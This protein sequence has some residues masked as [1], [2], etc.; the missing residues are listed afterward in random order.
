MTLLL[1][2]RHGEND[3]MHRRMAG[4]LP[5]V[6]L[7]ESGRQQA[8]RLAQA[9]EHA[10]IQAIY[11]S[12]M[13]RAQ[14]TAAP[15]ARSH[16]LPVQICDGLNEVHYGDWQGRTYKQLSRLK[17]WKTLAVAPSQVRMPQGESFIEVQNRVVSQLEALTREDDPEPVP[18]DLDGKE[19]HEKVIAVVAHGD[20]VRLAVAHYLNM[21]LDD[22]QRLHVSLASVTIVHVSPK[23]PP[24]VIAVNQIPGFSWPEP[25]QPSQKPSRKKKNHA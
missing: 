20:V 10:P 4:R 6:H 12:P 5:G 11:S 24:Q 25:P 7:N 8:E 18:A 14:E 3:L 17:L 13:E 15:L 21:A 2:I 16:N 19:P 22:F 1:L 23:S 9:L